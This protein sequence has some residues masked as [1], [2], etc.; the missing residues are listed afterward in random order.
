MT[1]QTLHRKV[2]KTLKQREINMSVIHSSVTQTSPPSKGLV[3]RCK[4]E[5]LAKA[6]RPLS[7]NSGIAGSEQQGHKNYSEFI[8]QATTPAATSLDAPNEIIYTEG[9]PNYIFNEKGR[10]RLKVRLKSEMEVSAINHPISKQTQDIST[11]LEKNK[12]HLNSKTIFVKNLRDS[13]EKFHIHISELTFQR[14]KLENFLSQELARSLSYTFYMK[15][16]AEI[17]DFIAKVLRSVLETSLALE[18]AIAFPDPALLEQLSSE[19]LAELEIDGP[20]DFELFVVADADDHSDPFYNFV[21]VLDLA[22]DYDWFP[23]INIFSSAEA[24]KAGGLKKLA[25]SWSPRV[26]IIYDRQQL[27]VS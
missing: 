5:D 24:K 12:S 26:Y 3:L 10:F 6:R 20:D 27:A 25:E 21:P 13:H 2:N 22:D 11:S 1:S 4:M 15:D 18:V 14:N 16:D 17:A 7:A 9:F 23:Y 8:P 19:E